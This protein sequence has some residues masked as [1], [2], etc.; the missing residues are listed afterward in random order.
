MNSFNQSHLNK[1][2]RDKFHMVLS[3]P[4]ILKGINNDTLSLRGKEIISLDSIQFSIFGT[5]VP[6]I[7]V[8]GTTAGYAGQHYKVSTYSRPPY[9]DITV[10]FTV[11]NLYKNYWI[12]YKW[13]DVLND[14]K[15]SYFNRNN[16]PDLKVQ[17]NYQ[18][19]IVVYAKDEFDKNVMKFTYTKAFPVSLGGIN[20]SYRDSDE[21]ESSFTFAFSQ[22]I[23]EPI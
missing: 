19:D 17:N 16:L 14:D 6:N 5:I 3:L 20:Y 8:P 1:S 2:R 13:L 22:F 7:Q 4:P 21:I 23:S 9:E 10:N 15:D 18:T 11:D 12:I